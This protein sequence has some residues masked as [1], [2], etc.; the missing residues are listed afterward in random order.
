MNTFVIIGEADL[1][2]Y[3]TPIY[4]GTNKDFAMSFANIGRYVV[5]EF[6]SEGLYLTTHKGQFY[7]YGT[8]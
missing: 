8:M 3:Y 1:N 5:M 4:A 2:Q 7:Y 6:D